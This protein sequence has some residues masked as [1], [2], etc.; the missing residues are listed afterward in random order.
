LF[1]DYG[2]AVSQELRATEF[3][4]S[5]SRI[6]IAPPTQFIGAHNGITFWND[7]GREVA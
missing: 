2:I 4:N 6:S 1:V 5:H 7:L 3:V